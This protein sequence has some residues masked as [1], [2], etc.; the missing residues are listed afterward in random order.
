MD[1]ADTL[2]TP[3]YHVCYQAKCGNSR[4]KSTSVINEILW[5]FSRAVTHWSRS[6]QLLY[7]EPG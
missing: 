7:M 6:M 5:R 3:L 1:V 2:E 4:L